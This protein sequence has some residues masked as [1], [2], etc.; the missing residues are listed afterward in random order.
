MTTLAT[1]AATTG[2]R[3]LDDVQFE[4]WV[5]LLETR[6]GVIVPPERRPFLETGL[7]RRMRETGHTRFDV[8]YDELLAGA[9]GALEWASLVD[10]LTVHETHFFRH[11]P[12]LDLIRQGWLPGWLQTAAPDASLH[13]LSVGCS[14]GEEAYSLALMLDAEFSRIS[15]VHRFGVT[16][17][18]VSQAALAIARVAEYPMR[19]FAEIPAA[20]RAGIEI[21]P[22][23]E[24]FRIAERLRKR[25]GFACVNLLHASRAPL[26][27][28]DIIF[29][30]NV[31]IYFARERRGE[32]LDALA[33]LLRPNGLL[34]LGSGEAPGWSHARM[35]RTGGPQTLA[36]LRNT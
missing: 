16:A 35:R 30:Q 29:C 17:T 22:D 7:R 1:A 14:T 6:T 4:R 12:S 36:F 20:Y 21:L 31:L 5:R 33:G 25:V 11:L 24:N 2:T 34:V 18:D 9:R 26:R 27:K 13:A 23:G 10:H 3:P 28:L 15:P 19:R 8:Y 32:L